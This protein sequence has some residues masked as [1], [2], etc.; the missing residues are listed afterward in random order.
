MTIIVVIFQKKTHHSCWVIFTTMKN[1]TQN[2]V[3]A[4]FFLLGFGWPLPSA[5]AQTYCPPGS[6]V[7]PCM[8]FEIQNCLTCTLNYV[9]G[10][11]D[12][13]T[14]GVNPGGA[15]PPQSSSLPPCVN[16][17]ILVTA[18]CMTEQCDGGNCICAT[19]WYIVDQTVMPPFVDRWGDLRY[20]GSGGTTLPLVYDQIPFGGCPGCTSGK[21]K[22]TWTL[23]SGGMLR[24]TVE[25]D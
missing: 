12:G 17:P 19:A 3:L 14:C 7:P 13:T 23:G 1:K 8:Q 22:V 11:V 16:P 6:C 10:F 21:I 15:I 18:P 9:F 5:Q 24:A 25:C 4:I 2:L 20:I